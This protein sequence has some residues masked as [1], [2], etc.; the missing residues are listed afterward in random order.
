MKT[1]TAIPSSTPHARTASAKFALTGLIAASAFCALPASSHAQ[2]SA[3]PFTLDG[4]FSFGGEWSDVTPNAFISAPGVA[5]IPTTNTDPA[6]NTLLYAAI[7][8][9][10]TSAP[11]DLQLHLMYDFLPRTQ[12]PLAGEAFATVTFPVTRQ[13]ALGNDLPKDNISVIFV[14]NGLPSFF[15]IFV[16]LDI[17]S[18]SPLVPIAAVPGLKGAASA[19]G[20][21]LSAVPHLLVELEVGLRIPSGFGDDRPGGLPGGG[22]N[23]ATGLYD[24]DPVFWGAAGSGDGTQASPDGG[25]GAGGPLQSATAAMIEI[26]PSGGLIVTVPEPTS[27]ALLLAG[28]GAFAARRRRPLSA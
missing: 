16:D 13:D 7:S 28:V 17:N 20:S 2:I 12:I 26:T 19:A 1:N 22:I 23:P 14:G 5:A 15:D 24:P 4:Q 18:P 11:G 6:R 21:S 25:Q 3:F 8:H 10:V 9:N 27:A